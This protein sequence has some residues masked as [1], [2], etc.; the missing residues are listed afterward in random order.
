MDRVENLFEDAVYVETVYV[1]GV[2]VRPER[3][4]FDLGAWLFRAFGGRLY[5]EWFVDNEWATTVWGQR[6]FDTVLHPW[7]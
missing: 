5:E 6:W 7:G 4:P 2:D 1:E 3:E